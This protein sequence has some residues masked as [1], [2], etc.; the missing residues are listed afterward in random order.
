MLLSICLGRHNIGGGHLDLTAIAPLI[1][2]ANGHLGSLLEDIS[3][4]TKYSR[5]VTTV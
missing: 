1:Q 3:M 2:Q 4:L 5:L